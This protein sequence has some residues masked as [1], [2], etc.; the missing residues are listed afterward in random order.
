MDKIFAE[1]FSK[2]PDEI[3]DSDYFYYDIWFEES[4]AK[5]LRELYKM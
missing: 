4:L 1:I 3:I 5:E 2:E